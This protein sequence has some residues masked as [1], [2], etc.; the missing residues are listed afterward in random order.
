MKPY[1]LGIDI[2]TS[3]CKVA[4]FDKTGKVIASAN[5]NYPV[6]YPKPGW[7]EQNPE[8]WWRAVCGAIKTILST[9]TVKA[10]EIAG[11]GI[12]G[13]SWSAIAVD[14]EG[15]VLTNTPIWMDTRAEDI[16][17]ELNTAIGEDMIF[18]LSGNSLQ[19][20]YTTAK[21][22]WYKRNMPELYK[23]IHKILQSNSYLAFKLT[24]KITQDLSQGYGLHCF[25]MHTGTWN[26]EMCE[27]LGISPEMLPEIY[28]CHEVIGTVTRK[29]A[30]ESG[31]LEGTPVVA[32][33]LDAACGTLGAGVIHS[34]ETQEQ[35]GQAGG[36]SICIDSYKADKNLILGFHVIPDRWLLQGGTTGGGGVM[37]WLEQEFADYEREE[38][39]RKGKSSLELFNELAE[40]VEAGSDGMVFLPYMAGERSPIWDS[41]AKGVY[42]GLDFSKTKGHF[43]RGAM[44]GVAFSL[45]HNLETA[46]K[47]GAKV[48]TL[49][50]MGGSANSYL[51]TQIKAD[52]TGKPITVPASDTASTL[53]AA[54][55]AG[56]G[57]GVY[58]SFEEAVSL[59]VVNKRQHVP[60][61]ANHEIYQRNYEIYLKLYENLKEVMKQE[62]AVKE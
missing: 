10:D 47:A 34:G 29:A 25:D 5:G 19:P 8:E 3:A 4:V 40:K 7:A 12:D 24:D 14:K 1:L 56:V 27:K 44:E 18:Q 41:K 6:Y 57:V 30:E 46:Q 35:G 21:I 43:I 62:G 2:G 58:E 23:R 59:T 37:R 50:A 28:P 45:R 42:Y 61:K 60:N 22:I 11:I 36:M 49:R 52:V 26:N 32:G 48:D 39:K 13:Q 15:A 16:C 55:L 38:G 54:I 9:L 20:A 53:G 31:L 17:K 33:G 51:W